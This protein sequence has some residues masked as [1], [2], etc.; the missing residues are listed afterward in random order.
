MTVGSVTILTGE[1]VRT[2]SSAHSPPGSGS[3]KTNHP[4]TQRFK[5]RGGLFLLAYLQVAG[6]AL[7]QAEAPGTLLHFEQVG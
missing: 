1:E 6:T 2:G 4:Q 3:S 7:P 5:A